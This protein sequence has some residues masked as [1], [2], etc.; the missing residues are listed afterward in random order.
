MP[1]SSRGAL[2]KLCRNRDGIITVKYMLVSA[3]NS[4]PSVKHLDGVTKQKETCHP[5]LSF[6]VQPPEMKENA[7]ILCILP[8]LASTHINIPNMI[9]PCSQ[10]KGWL[11]LSW[12]WNGPL[13]VECLAKEDWSNRRTTNW[14]TATPF[15]ESQPRLNWLKQWSITRTNNISALKHYCLPSQ[16]NKTK[17]NNSC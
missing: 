12:R 15:P 16:K 1:S 10:A 6:T 7:F 8:W 5:E 9:V 17:Q 11:L 13:D 14:K 2:L 3:G 4:S